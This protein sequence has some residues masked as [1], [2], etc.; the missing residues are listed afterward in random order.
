MN[1]SSSEQSPSDSNTDGEGVEDQ[2]NHPTNEISTSFQEL[3]EQ[4]TNHFCKSNTKILASRCGQK[5]CLSMSL[6]L[7][8]VAPIIE[9]LNDVSNA[10]EKVNNVADENVQQIVAEVGQQNDHSID[11]QALLPKQTPLP[12]TSLVQVK[13]CRRKLGT[14]LLN[15]IFRIEILFVDFHFPYDIRRCKIPY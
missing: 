15:T 8:T 9:Q 12:T 1:H 3:C 6:I 4:H 14:I 7:A 13:K 5:T 10:V 2:N 11:I